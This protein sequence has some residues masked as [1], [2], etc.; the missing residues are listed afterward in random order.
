M[1]PPPPPSSPGPYPSVAT[2]GSHPGPSMA[3]WPVS[4]GPSWCHRWSHSATDIHDC[5]KIEHSNI[6]GSV[7]SSCPKIAINQF[8]SIRSYS[9]IQWV[10]RYA[11]GH[12]G[13]NWTLFLN[14]FA[15]PRHSSCV[16]DITMLIQAFNPPILTCSTHTCDMRLLGYLARLFSTFISLLTIVVEL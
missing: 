11:A 3:L 8:T 7:Q 14:C 13:H 5:R 4:L 2:A 16:F 10:I 12:K 1:D 9:R 6:Y 15:T